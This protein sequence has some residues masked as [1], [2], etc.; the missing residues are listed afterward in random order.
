MNELWL[1]G[2]GGI[3]C[4]RAID[5]CGGAEKNDVMWRKMIIFAN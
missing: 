5:L 2:E 1:V 4:V 3:S